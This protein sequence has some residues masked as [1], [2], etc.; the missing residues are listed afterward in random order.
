MVLVWKWHFQ[1]ITPTASIIAADCTT[2]MADGN[3]KTVSYSW[4][5][6]LLKWFL[7]FQELTSDS[8][9]Q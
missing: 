7:H 4:V 3:V 6:E 1:L 8:G 2:V 9:P 5:M